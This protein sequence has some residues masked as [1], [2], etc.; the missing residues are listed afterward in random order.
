MNKEDKQRKEFERVSKVVIKYLNNYWHPHA[1]MIVT[2]TGSEVL[3][4]ELIMA[5]E[6]Y[7]K[8]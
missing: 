8:D 3:S 1:K 5:T 2:T 7:L 6:K 4:G